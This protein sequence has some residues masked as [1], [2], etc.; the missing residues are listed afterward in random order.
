MEFAVVD[1]WEADGE[2]AEEVAFVPEQ[3]SAAAD[4]LAFGRGPVAH[5]AVSLEDGIFLLQVA[6]DLAGVAQVDLAVDGIGVSALPESGSAFEVAFELPEMDEDA[7]ESAAQEAGAGGVD[8]E[9]EWFVADFG[10]TRESSFLQKFQAALGRHSQQPAADGLVIEAFDLEAEMRFLG[11][12]PAGDQTDGPSGAVGGHFVFQQH[13]SIVGA[14]EDEA[15]VV[16]PG[17]S[18]QG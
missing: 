1:D 14:A 18:K 13:V 11:A 6:I 12:L 10:S 4:P 16:P 15:G 9:R 3:I 7:I 8:H 2:I 17:A 5:K